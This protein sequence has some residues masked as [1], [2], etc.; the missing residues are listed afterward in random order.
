M[1]RDTDHAA[2]SRS[3]SRKS[4]EPGFT[5]P[6]RF[7][8][9]DL[10][11]VV[12]P[13]LGRLAEKLHRGHQILAGALGRSASWVSR[14]KDPTSEQYRV[15][16]ELLPQACQAVGS[17]EPVDELFKGVRIDGSEWRMG[18]VPE[19]I[20]AADIQVRSMELAGQAGAY[21]QALVR[22]LHGGLSRRERAELR[23]YLTQLR[24][25]VDALIAG[26]A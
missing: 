17:V 19:S 3:S 5:D 7:D 11:K 8:F 2:A 24:A 22:R 26:L 15:P 25:Q 18:R 9:A 21:M 16:K 4:D 23:E 6:V 13:V 12:E 14:M 1:R 10:P 20:A